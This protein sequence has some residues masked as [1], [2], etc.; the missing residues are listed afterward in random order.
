MP[1]YDADQFDPPA[2]VAIVSVRDP[3]SSCT[4]EKISMLIDSGADVSLLPGAVLEHLGLRR[5]DDDV[6]ELAGFDNTRSASRA[7][8]ATMVWGSRAF[9]GRFLT[10]DSSYGILGRNILN[11]VR[12]VLDGPR[13]YWE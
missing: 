8:Q 4:V 2:P 1:A 6:Y 9:T 11:H 13:L 5:D 12:I 7:V 3:S 10:S